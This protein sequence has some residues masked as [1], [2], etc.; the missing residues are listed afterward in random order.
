MAKA[1]R[2]QVAQLCEALN[3]QSRRAEAVELIR[4]LVDKIVLT[5]IKIDGKKTLKIDL[6]GHLAGILSLSA[7]T[8]KPLTESDFFVESIKM[9]AGARNTLY[10]LFSA[11]GLRTCASAFGVR[12]IC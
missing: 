5:P 6:H 9:V 8:K 10:L 11:R 1:Y 3:E 4:S 7:N 12:P 2:D